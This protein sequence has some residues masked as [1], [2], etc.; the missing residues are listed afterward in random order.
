MA[1]AF[2]DDR[3]SSSTSSKLQNYEEDDTNLDLE[4]IDIQKPPNKRPRSKGKIYE[5][6][7]TCDNLDTARDQLKN[8]Q[9]NFKWKQINQNT[10][11]IYYKC[12][13][14]ECSHRAYINC[15]QENSKTNIY[16]TEEYNEHKHLAT[17]R[18]NGLKDDVKALIRSAIDSGIK[19][20]T[21][22]MKM[23]EKKNLEAP[24]KLQLVNYL[25][26]Y[27]KKYYASS[28]ATSLGHKR[29]RSVPSLPK[30]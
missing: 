15:N 11:T 16:L 9:D 17:N 2:Q 20:P 13:V 14:K 27:K 23:I 10:E 30:Q 24:K 5:H 22:I 19:K 18:E 3:V 29:K 28:I 4:E 25:A 21:I 1:S 26:Y 7:K 12:S 6:W 8:L